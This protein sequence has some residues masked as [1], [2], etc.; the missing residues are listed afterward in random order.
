LVD[1]QAHLVDVLPERSADSFAAW[2]DAHP[3]VEARPAVSQRTK[4][5]RVSPIF[6]TSSTEPAATAITSS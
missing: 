1:M 6:S 4:D 2:L 5:R 3:G